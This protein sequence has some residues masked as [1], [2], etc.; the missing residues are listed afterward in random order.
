MS[1]MSEFACGTVGEVLSLYSPCPKISTEA[2]MPTL[3]IPE[4]YS[5]TQNCIFE[6]KIVFL[7]NKLTNFT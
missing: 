5:T 2:N 6:Y 3:K 4:M 7:K 1:P